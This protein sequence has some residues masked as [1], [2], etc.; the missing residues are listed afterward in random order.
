VSIIF[1]C[2]ILETNVEFMVGDLFILVDQDYLFV[3]V[4]DLV[5]KIGDFEFSSILVV[6]FTTIDK[7]EHFFGYFMMD[8]F[9]VEY[10]DSM[11]T[12]FK[13]NRVRIIVFEQLVTIIR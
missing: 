1:T 8:G 12:E 6:H 3:E 13:T 2:T 5:E 9:L 11:V 4:L 7:F 10:I